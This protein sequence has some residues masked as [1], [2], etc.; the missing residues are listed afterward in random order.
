MKTN[1]M[2]KRNHFI[3]PLGCLLPCANV[4]YAVP[5]A[6]NARLCLE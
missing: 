3:L 5:T 6:S 1:L 2:Q 4:L